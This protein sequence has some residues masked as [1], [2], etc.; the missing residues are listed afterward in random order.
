MELRTLRFLLPLT[1][2]FGFWFGLTFLK[3]FFPKELFQWGIFAFI[4]I[5]AV[6]AIAYNFVYEKKRAE[7]I[8]RLARLRGYQYIEKPGKEFQS[9]LPDFKLLSLGYS[10]KAKNVLKLKS[11]GFHWT[12][13]DY[14]YATGGGR[15]TSVHFQSVAITDLNKD[16][17]DFSFTKKSM[18]VAFSGYLRGQK[19]H[20]ENKEFAKAYIVRGSEKARELFSPS[21][22][23][24]FL[25]LS[26]P[27]TG[28]VLG[29]KLILR[30]PR[31]MNAEELTSFLEECSR[32]AKQF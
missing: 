16:V 12:L 23:Q 15:S 32:L 30:W 9:K 25:G 19:L 22:I 28:E 1:V 2:V 18:F 27:L 29:N 6:A 3:G 13:F 11:G 21:L 4:L 14:R 20:I 24:A 26:V 17:P 8:K 7:A 5:L 31:R 10:R